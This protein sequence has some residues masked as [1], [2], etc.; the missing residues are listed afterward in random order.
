MQVGY[1]SPLKYSQS[2]QDLSHVPEKNKW[3]YP[4]RKQGKEDYSLNR[5]CY[6]G[7]SNLNDL[8]NPNTNSPHANNS[9]YKTNAAKTSKVYTFPSSVSLPSDLQLCGCYIKDMDKNEVEVNPRTVK[10]SDLLKS[11]ESFSAYVRPR[12]LQLDKTLAKYKVHKSLPVSPVNEERCLSDFVNDRGGH[13]VRKSFSYFIDFDRKKTNE[14]F[15]KICR[16]IEEFSKGFEEGNNEGESVQESEKI[17]NIQKEVKEYSKIEE[18]ENKEIRIEVEGSFCLQED[19]DGNFSSD[20]LEDYSFS[21]ARHTKNSLNLPPRRCVSNNEIYNYNI[22]DEVNYSNYY[23]SYDC[24]VQK[25]ESFYLNQSNKNSRES[26]LSGDELYEDFRSKSYCNSMESILSNESDCKSAPLEALFTPFRLR[27]SQE[28]YSNS[29]RYY[30]SNLIPLQYNSRPEVKISQ[31]SRSLPKNMYVDENNGLLSSTAVEMTRSKSFHNTEFPKIVKTM[32]T[33]QT[34]TDLYFETPEEIVAKK[35]YASQDFQKKLL[36]FETVIAQSNEG[37]CFKKGVAFFVNTGDLIEGKMKSERSKERNGNESNDAIKEKNEVNSEGYEASDEINETG[38]E[39]EINKVRSE[40]ND[41]KSQI[42]E[43]ISEVN[44]N[45]ET[46]KSKDNPEKTKQINPNHNFESVLE[47]K[48]KHKANTSCKFNNK[49]MIIPSLESKN[50]QY[51]SRFCNVLN[52]RPRI[53]VEIFDGGPLI[54]KKPNI[55]LTTKNFEGQSDKLGCGKNFGVCDKKFDGKAKSFQGNVK[56]LSGSS[57]NYKRSTENYKV[58]SENYNISSGS[59][60]LSSDNYSGSCKNF[61]CV[62]KFENCPKNQNSLRES[63]SLD[64]HLLT[65]SLLGGEKVVHKPPKGLRRHSTKIKK[66]K[67]CYEYVKKDEFYRSRDKNKAFRII[68]GDCDNEIIFRSDSEM[69]RNPGVSKNDKFYENEK[70]IRK[71]G[72]EF[73][74]AKEDFVKDFKNN[75]DRFN[76]QFKKIKE[77]K[78]NNENKEKGN[79]KSC[80]KNENTDKQSDFKENNE[81]KYRNE[82]QEKIIEISY[83]EKNSD[84]ECESYIFNELYDSLDKPFLHSKQ[85]FDSLELNINTTYEEAHKYYDSLEFDHKNIWSNREVEHRKFNGKICVPIL[86]DIKHRNIESPVFRK[87]TPQLTIENLKI[88]NEIER[89]I[90]KINALVDLFKRNLYSGKVKTLS[91]MYETMNNSQSFYNTVEPIKFRRRNLSLPNFVERRLNTEGLDC[92]VEEIKYRSWKSEK[93]DTNSKGWCKNGKERDRSKECEQN[94][95][96]QGQNGKNKKVE[97]FSEISMKGDC[98]NKELLECCSIVSVYKCMY[99]L[100]NACTC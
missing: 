58:N 48:N 84:V 85:D 55:A 73:C 10:L 12:K 40:R 45:N 100:M 35:S 31:Y 8:Q 43:T 15:M 52:N 67:T 65:K 41:M 34:Q 20:S 4:N 50:N 64:R 59:Y 13:A 5:L 72:T 98:C 33:S 1:N 87:D 38:N 9:V 27:N 69:C 75:I 30:G 7:N 16:D 49:Q 47:N 32:K 86:S 51:K 22:Q 96:G 60:D 56:N 14:G 37:C 78:S 28:E 70:K 71:N 26:I 2:I 44:K 81:T 53:N 89:K 83:K 57:D 6:C 61:K 80:K 88:L 79:D 92:L 95:K 94:D 11:P 23:H 25:S 91:D 39:N 97:D 24:Q 29:S 74:F 99:M 63:S 21:S 76:N 82:N 42:N 62:E 18:D 90:K 77:K 17:K 68:T 36:K 46:N 3:N 93:R 19:E 66:N 54:F